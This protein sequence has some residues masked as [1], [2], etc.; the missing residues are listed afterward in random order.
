MVFSR[1]QSQTQDPDQV[2]H[3]DL[4]DLLLDT[5]EPTRRQLMRQLLQSGEM[6]KSEANDLMALVVRLER[7]AGPRHLEPKPEAR[8]RVAWGIDY[9]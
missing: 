9:P 8:P 2:S 6:D 7:V 5:D 4:I 1:K 3:T